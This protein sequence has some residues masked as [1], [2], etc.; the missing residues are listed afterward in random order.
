V[1]TPTPDRQRIFHSHVAGVSFRSNGEYLGTVAVRGRT[2]WS[3]P[4]PTRR[5]VDAR[6]SSSVSSLSWK[7]AAIATSSRPSR[8]LSNARQARLLSVRVRFL[9][10]IAI[11]SWRW[12][13]AKD[14]G[15]LPSGCGTIKMAT[16]EP[17]TQLSTRPP[18][19]DPSGPTGRLA[20]W[21]AGTKIE[22]VPSTVREHAK[23]LLLDGIACALVGAQLPVSRKG[24]AVTLIR[25]LRGLPQ[26]PI[27]A[28]LVGPGPLLDNRRLRQRHAGAPRRRA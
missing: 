7:S 24:A 26:K 10:A 4:T 11:S 14:A 3:S 19:T 18:P 16:A 17:V 8:L 6:R 15:H 21:L 20:T 2:G 23:Y 22:N 25:P 13:H 27:D 12:R 28:L 9:T 1:V 5:E